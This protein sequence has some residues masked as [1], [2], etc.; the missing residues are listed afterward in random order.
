MHYAE[1]IVGGYRQTSEIGLCIYIWLDDEK[2]PR[3]LRLHKILKTIAYNTG[4]ADVVNL[5]LGRARRKIRG[6]RRVR[7]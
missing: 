6:D 7:L 3:Q 4:R 5:P 2:I 1:I